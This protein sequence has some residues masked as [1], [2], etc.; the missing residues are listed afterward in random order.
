MKSNLDDGYYFG[1]GAFETIKVKQQK[2]ILLKEHLERL[3]GSLQALNIKQH[4]SKEQVKSYIMSQ[5]LVDG[6]L[7]IC[8]S[9]QNIHYIT[10]DNQYTAKMYQAGY[11]LAVSP[12]LRNETSPLTYIKSLNHADNILAKQYAKEN[13]Y[14]EALLLN[15]KGAISE[16]SSGN[17]FFV[18]GDCL[19]T[20]SIA[21]GLLPGIIRGVIC[22]NEE[23][24]ETEIL[25]DQIKWYD[26]CFLTNSIMGIMR[27][28]SIADVDFKSNNIVAKMQKK[29]QKFY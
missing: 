11:K 5:G 6:V 28:V 17:I 26:E 18:K 8:V 10:R 24:V 22:K 23:V 15:T 27:V 3:N 14:D 16:A 29:Y 21:C 12:I 20:P 2:G 19:F 13:N 7:K 9:E 25:L 4:L 1:I